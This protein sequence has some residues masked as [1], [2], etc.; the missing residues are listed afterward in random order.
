MPRAA[1]QCATGSAGSL[2]LSHAQVGSG[3]GPWKD[4]KGTGSCL[5]PLSRSCPRNL[6]Q[7][8]PRHIS[9][10]A[11]CLITD[12]RLHVPWLISEGS[13]EVDIIHFSE[14][15]ALPF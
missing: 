15:G 8:P 5:G 10:E 3:K 4:K 1:S 13:S 11:E 9:K 7:F 2:L 14:R 6:T 12:L